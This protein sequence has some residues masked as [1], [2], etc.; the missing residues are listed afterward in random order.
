MHHRLVKRMSDLVNGNDSLKLEVEVVRGHDL[1]PMDRS[2]L[3][4]PYVKLRIGNQKQKTTSIK[5]TLHPVWKETMAFDN[6]SSKYTLELRVL[7]KDKWRKSEFMGQCKISLE[8]VLDN[9]GCFTGWFSLWDEKYENREIGTIH[10]RLALVDPKKTKVNRSF[11]RELTENVV[12]EDT[13]I[14]VGSWNVGNAAPEDIGCWIPQTGYDIYAIGVQECKYDSPDP[15]ASSADVHWLKVLQKHLK[16]YSE[17]VAHRSIGEMRLTIFAKDKSRVSRLEFASEATG[18]GHVLANKGGV[19]I[20]FDYDST[21]VCFLNSHLAA[22]QGMIKQR[23]EN[24]GEICNGISNKLGKGLLSSFHHV[25]WMGDLNYRL[26]MNESDEKEPTP[27]LFEK[28]TGM[29]KDENYEELYQY[30]QLCKEISD[31]NTF[32]GFTQAGTPNFAPT[33]KV[34]RQEIGQ[35]IPKRTPS[36]CDRML[37]RSITGFNLKQTSFS[38]TPELS[39]SDHKPVSGEF[40]METFKLPSHDPS[41]VRGKLVFESIRCE[42]LVAADIGG[43]SDPYLVIHS[44]VFSRRYVS[45]YKKKTLD[46]SWTEEE[47]PSQVM[48]VNHKQAIPYHFLSVDIF[49]KD[50]QS[51]DDFIGHCAIP[52]RP[53]VGNLNQPNF[54]KVPVIHEGKHHGML[55]ATIR[56]EWD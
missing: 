26:Q 24:Y 46:P 13:R 31:G 25:I 56:L 16:G 33:F 51:S 48:V 36:W 6:V 32:V 22:H 28:I 1:K 10:L 5:Q 23:N 14:W 11:T 42:G 39:S 43:S 12:V 34:E 3:S 45:N 47:L 54:F 40:T 53:L 7:D 41:A 19:A 55:F 44:R 8:Q 50:R 21:S 4:D 18:I 37:W 29:I 15:E 27:E 35:Y 20:G 30:D 17:F 38:S 2:G 52:L 9:Q 49:D